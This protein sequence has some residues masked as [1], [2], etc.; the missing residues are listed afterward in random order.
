M[1]RM[2][3]ISNV[4]SSICMRVVCTSIGNHEPSLRQPNASTGAFP[5]Q[6]GLDARV[7]LARRDDQP[8]RLPDHRLLA[9]AKQPSRGSAKAK[10][11]RGRRDRDGRRG[12]LIVADS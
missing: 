3:S 11:E 2:L 4:R 1:S 7:V 8:Q 12:G 5:R 10:A 9:V 6:H